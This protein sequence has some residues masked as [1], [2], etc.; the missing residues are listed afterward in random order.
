MKIKSLWVSEYKNIVDQTFNFNN[1]LTSL[2]IG[3]NGLGKSNLLEIIALILKELDLAEKEDDLF[4]S[5][6][7]LF[8]DFKIEYECRSN[9]FKIAKVGSELKIKKHE[10][11]IQRDFNLKFNDFKLNK[12]IYLPDFIIGYYSGENKRI[13]EIFSTHYQRRL[14]NLKSTKN[15][16]FPA[17][18]KF[19]FTDQNLGELLFFTLWV[20]KDTKIYGG[21][22]QTLLV[23]YIGIEIGSDVNISFK[24]PDFSKNF[25][26][27]NA[28]NLYDNIQNNIE[29][30]FWG[31]QGKLDEFL[32]DLFNNNSSK[33]LPPAY[34]D[35][36]KNKEEFVFF[37]R[38]DYL[39][40]KDEL[41]ENFNSPTKLFDILHA[42]ESIGIINEIE[43]RISKN[44]AQIS[45]NFSELSEGEQQLLTILG[46]LLITGESDSLYI[47]D[48]PDTHLNPIWQRNFINLL[49]E[50]NFNDDNSQI[51]VATHSP[52][53][54]QNT[55][56]ANLLLLRK[57]GDKVIIDD[58][59][60]MIENWRIDQVLVSEYFDLPTAR[61][62]NLDQYMETREAILKKEEITKNDEFKLKEF[63]N[64]FGVFPTGETINDIKAML[65]IRK[66]TEKID[67]K[68]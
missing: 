22:I 37:D 13:K 23:D 53:I 30:P 9:I 62:S 66:I 56:N 25:P 65:L 47:F 50:F 44:G 2:I 6:T 15:T 19:F 57:D 55:K 26:D 18:G 8:F 33:S 46:L 63:Q 34:I 32:R 28:D 11:S 20:F 29:H 67:D 48:E 54:V 61:P 24:N 45:H 49:K 64:D 5:K 4:S 12:H 17:L 21:K 10:S 41:S 1:G 68:T 52:L 27:K 60:H 35:D 31:I 51:L 39:T 58:G 40:L 3:Q 43:T 14:T 7:S 42:A 16:K 59:N 38:L 36:E